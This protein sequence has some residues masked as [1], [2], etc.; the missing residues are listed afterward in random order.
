MSFESAEYFAHLAL[1]LDIFLHLNKY[2]LYN[3]ARI[4]VEVN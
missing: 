1:R 3:Y 2:I 4:M